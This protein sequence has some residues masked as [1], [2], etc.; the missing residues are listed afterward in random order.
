MQP[1]RPAEA[2]LSPEKGSRDMMDVEKQLPTTPLPLSHQSIR[3]PSRLAF[4][5]RRE[6]YRELPGNRSD[7]SIEIFLLRDDR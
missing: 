5:A 4:P 1:I 6:A 7:S 2:V 3:P